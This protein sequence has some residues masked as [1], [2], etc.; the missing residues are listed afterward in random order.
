MSYT[1]FDYGPIRVSQPTFGSADRVTLSVDV[2]NTG[3]RDGIETVHWFIHDKVASVTRPMKELK[4]FER[5]EIRA[6]ETV[7]FVWELDPQRDL[8][9]V[10]RDGRRHLEAGEFVIY[11]GAK[12]LS[13]TLE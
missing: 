2:T 5:K 8:S 13:V 10:D 6:G 3:G 1:R 7:T 9:F 11:A 4:H 12:A